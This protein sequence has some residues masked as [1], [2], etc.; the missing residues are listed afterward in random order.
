MSSMDMSSLNIE[1]LQLENQNL[2]EELEKLKLENAKL[3]KQ[4]KIYKRNVNKEEIDYW[5][6]IASKWQS[7]S[8]SKSK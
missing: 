5:K 1:I 2:K 8:Q 4:F 6:A 7:I 3:K